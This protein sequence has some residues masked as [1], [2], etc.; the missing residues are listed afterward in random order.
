MSKEVTKEQSAIETIEADEGSRESQAPEDAFSK[1]EEEYGSLNDRHLRLM[2]EFDNFKK[3]SDKER[4]TAIRYANEA[5]LLEL[6][7]I[8]DNLE[9]ALLAAQ[10]GQEEGVK[11]QGIAKGVEMVLKLFQDTLE[12]FGVCSF[13]AQGAL[14]DP[15]R[16]EAVAEQENDTVAPGTVCME[17]QKGYTLHERLVRPARVVVA[18]AKP[19]NHAVGG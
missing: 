9:S 17:Y 16:H 19:I 12:R 3:R 11:N 1:L 2:A 15:N 4:Q 10:N 14:F 5:I 8:I 13:S 6:L 18:K 7:P